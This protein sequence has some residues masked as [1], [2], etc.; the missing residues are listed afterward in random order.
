MPQTFP[1]LRWHVLYVDSHTKHVLCSFC[2]TG[3]WL[4]WPLTRDPRCRGIRD[5]IPFSQRLIHLS[6]V[7]V[8]LYVLLL[9]FSPQVSSVSVTRL[10]LCLSK[11][12]LT[13]RCIYWPLHS[14]PNSE[15]YNYAYVL[16]RWFKGVSF[17]LHVRCDSVSCSCLCCYVL[18]CIHYSM[19]HGEAQLISMVT[20]WVTGHVSKD[21]I[22]NSPFA[23]MLS[24]GV[25][26]PFLVKSRAA[27][28]I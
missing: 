12:M 5:M 8:A 7:A 11:V 13:L 6:E 28:E 26:L 16:L 23:A 1:L 18:Q 21:T 24:T 20:G 9:G 25:H 2:M 22:G 14:M 27:V 3:L 15:T 10:V 4:C 17:W 19:G